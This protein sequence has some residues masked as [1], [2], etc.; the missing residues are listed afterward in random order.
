LIAAGSPRAVGLAR[1]HEPAKQAKPGRWNDTA[2]PFIGIAAVR[3]AMEMP[4]LED[5]KQIFDKATRIGRPDAAELG[6]RVRA[7]K[8]H[9]FRFEDDGETPNNP[10]LPLIWYRSP[11]RLRGARDPAS[12]FEELFA[13]NG[14]RDSW[15]DGI[16][17][18][19]HFHTRTHEVLG[20]ARG[21][22][23]AQFGGAHGKTIRLKAG[24]VVILPAGTG[25]R[26]L[27]KSRDL[28]VIGAYPK[29]GSY[30]EPR[31]AEIDRKK[32]LVAISRVKIPAKDPVYGKTGP[33]LAQWHD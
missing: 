14:W 22:V 31:P 21:Q 20:I 32:A 18:F 28:L 9:A 23:E 19:L 1:N 11:V 3:G 27:S 7:R 25:H 15:R 33:L 13:L 30:D 26:R 16:Y 29:T 2:A 6:A 24:D 17:D 10:R 8:P 4:I 12:V 5:A